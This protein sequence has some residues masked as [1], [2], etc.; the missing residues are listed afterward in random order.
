MCQYKVWRETGLSALVS[1]WSVQ[2]KFYWEH[3]SA[4]IVLNKKQR[5]VASTY[6]VVSTLPCEQFEEL[7]V[8]STGTRHREFAPVPSNRLRITDTRLPECLGSDTG[9]ANTIHV[10][11]TASTLEN[12]E[13]EIRIGLFATP[14]STTTR[15]HNSTYD[16]DCLQHQF[17]IPESTIQRTNW[18]VCNTQ[19][20]TYQNPQFNVRIGLFATPSSTH[21]RIHNSTYDSDCLQHP[22]WDT[23]ASTIQCTNGIVCKVRS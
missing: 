11:N 20:N 8:L 5:S 1:G 18:I 2:S 10:S 9:T 12:V 15:I 21:T 4:R 23:T 13:F 16:S 7:T 3:L 6:D 17:S 19:F 14:S 22:V